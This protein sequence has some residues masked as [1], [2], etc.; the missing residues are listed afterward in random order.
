MGTKRSSKHRPLD[1]RQGKYSSKPG[2][3]SWA[4]AIEIGPDSLSRE[5]IIALLKWADPNGCYTDEESDL[6]GYERLTKD[7]AIRAMF[8]LEDQ[9]NEIEGE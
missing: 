5:K 4:H 8:S 2:M 3:G 6:E 9:A 1:L 7:D